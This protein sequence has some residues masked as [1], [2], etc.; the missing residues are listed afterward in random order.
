MAGTYFSITVPLRELGNVME[1]AKNMNFQ[2]LEE[3]M[4]RDKS[5]IREFESMQY[6]FFGMIKN[7]AEGLKVRSN[8]SGLRQPIIMI[9]PS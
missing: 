2:Q 4:K 6:S 1:T 7:F 3:Y 9:T 5:V 8:S